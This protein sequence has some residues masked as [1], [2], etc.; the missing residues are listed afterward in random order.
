VG[1]DTVVGLICGLDT[2]LFVVLERGKATAVGLICELC[3]PG[4]VFVEREK[5][6]ASV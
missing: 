6:E 3:I 4:C 2:A 1:K 5:G